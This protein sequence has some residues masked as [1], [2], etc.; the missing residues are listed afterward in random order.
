[1]GGQPGDPLN[2]P[3]LSV[4]GHTQR[5][6]A[7][8]GHREA[9]GW[10]STLSEGCLYFFLFFQRRLRLVALSGCLYSN[11]DYFYIQCEY[12]WPAFPRLSPP[13]PV[14][15]F[16]PPHTL[17][18]LLVS[19]TLCLISLAAFRLFK[20]TVHSTRVIFKRFVNFGSSIRC[21]FSLIYKRLV[22]HARPGFCF[23]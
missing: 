19:E 16:Q 4:Q 13:S 23:L 8:A 6:S 9:R 21:I 7:W 14:P 2:F 17:C 20:G 10:E 1:M 15:L 18:A 12:P 3:L 22:Q 11:N 5:E